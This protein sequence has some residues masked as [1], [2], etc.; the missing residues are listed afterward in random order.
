[1]RELVFLAEE[2]VF[3]S[4]AGWD[5]GGAAACAC[6]SRRSP[7]S[8][9]QPYWRATVRLTLR[10]ERIMEAA[11]PPIHANFFVAESDVAYAEPGEEASAEARSPRPD[12]AVIA[13]GFR[14][15]DTAVL[16]ASEPA[17]DGKGWVAR[18]ANPKADLAVGI[19]AFAVCTHGTI[20]YP[21]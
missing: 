2:L 19:K 6:S 10:E 18:L 9:R 4:E 7:R 3:A 16:L 21:G 13:G 20:L 12:W 8:I 11:G 1:M 14:C 5:P 17:A 15:S